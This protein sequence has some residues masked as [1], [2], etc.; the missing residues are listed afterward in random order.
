MYVHYMKL[1]KKKKY[2][3][4]QGDLGLAGLLQKT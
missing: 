1:L 2:T 4:T 3:E